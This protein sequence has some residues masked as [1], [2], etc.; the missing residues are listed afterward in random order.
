MLFGSC[1]REAKEAKS[2]SS[3]ST[4]IAVTA[5][6]DRA[7]CYISILHGVD[8]NCYCKQARYGVAIG[9]AWGNSSEYASID[10][11]VASV[12]LPL[13]AVRFTS[14]ANYYVT[15]SLVAREV[16]EKVPRP[17]PTLYYLAF[18]AYPVSVIGRA[19]W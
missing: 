8:K 12:Q 14:S 2:N 19:L 7:L 9:L 5:H 1:F 18:C 13:E 6:T 4:L 17:R 11:I 10:I 16:Y 3:S 15:L